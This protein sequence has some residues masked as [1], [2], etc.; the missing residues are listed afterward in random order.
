MEAR[1][2]YSTMKTR[3]PAMIYR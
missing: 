1:H 3:S 2:I